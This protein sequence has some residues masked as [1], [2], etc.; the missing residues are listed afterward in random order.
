MKRQRKLLLLLIMTIGLNSAKSQNL[1]IGGTGNIGLSKVTSN[2]PIS[3]DYKTKFTLSGNMGMFLEKEIGQ[4]SSFGI[5]VL[6]VQIEGKEITENKELTAFNGQSVEVIG[7]ISDKST[8]HSSYVGI[9]VYCRFEFGKIGIKGGF[10]S[11]IFLFASS[12]YEASGEINGEPYEAKS[13]TKDIKFDRIGIG[14]K[15]GVDYQL[16]N[17]FRLR[18]DYYHGLTDITSAKFPW[19]RGIRQFN[20]GVN[21]IFGNNE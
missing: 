10:Q 8:L 14:P 7:V 21:Y 19:Q 6:W 18:A 12:N 16:N 2:L 17:K 1:V 11:M 4:K 20:W 15:V 5:E 13:K 9:P 3:G